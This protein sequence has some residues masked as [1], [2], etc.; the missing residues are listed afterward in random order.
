MKP[1]LFLAAI[2]FFSLLLHFERLVVPARLIFDEVY[3]VP[4]ARA[5]LAGKADPNWVHPPLAKALIAASI[6]LFG[7][8]PIGWRLASV[9]CA[10]P[11]AAFFFL[12]ARDLF[13]GGEGGTDAAVL[14][15]LLYLMD[16]ITYVQSRIA[17]LDMPMTGFLIPSIYFFRKKRYVLSS[18]FLGL[19]ASCKWGSLL[20]L[21]LYALFLPYK[22][23]FRKWGRAAAEILAPCFAVYFLLFTF[24]SAGIGHYSVNFFLKNY[25]ML[26]FHLRPTMVHP[27]KAQWWKWLLLI[28]PIWYAY[29][30]AANRMRG[31]VCLP[32]PLLWWPALIA[33]LMLVFRLKDDAARF[34]AAAVLFFTVPWAISIKGGFMYYLL[35][36]SPLMILALVYWVRK[37]PLSLALAFCGTLAGFVLFF[38]FYAY[39]SVPDAYFHHMFWLRSWI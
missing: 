11:A 7:D 37:T 35:P 17:T 4:A 26:K 29:A 34:I 30:G 22:S 21:P 20:A 16:G 14:A 23:G 25:E 8:S 24:M 1:A 31:V 36:A 38:P 15:S 19:S 6:R 5:M 12:L 13:G 32:N 39:L 3:Y 10:L 27:Y 33:S 18:L 2:L 9:A 28:R